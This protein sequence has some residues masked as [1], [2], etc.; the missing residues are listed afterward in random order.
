MSSDTSTVRDNE[1]LVVI[2]QVAYNTTYG[3]DLNLDGSPNGAM[4][5]AWTATALEVVP[6]SFEEGDGGSCEL[7]DAQNFQQDGQNGRT[8]LSFRLVVQCQAYLD[9]KDNKYNSRYTVD[10]ILQNGGIGWTKGDFVKVDMKGK[11]YK[12]RVTDARFTYVYANAGT[13]S[14]TTPVNTDGGALDLGLVVSNL[15][16]A[17]NTNVS[18][19]TAEYVGN[20]IRIVRDDGRDFNVSV[21][22]VRSTKP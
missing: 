7:V 22:A 18:G 5:Q 16:Q 8:G 10:A 4:Q 20:V 3:I 14:Y 6:G 13:V 19:F 2:N 21:E 11:R 9:E 15:T 17:I 12:V 1:G